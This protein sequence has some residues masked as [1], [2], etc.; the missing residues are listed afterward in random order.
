MINGID[1]AGLAD[2]AGVT[3]ELRAVAYCNDNRAG[4]YDFPFANSDNSNGIRIFSF[5]D[6]SNYS[7]TAGDSLHIFGT[8]AQFNGLLQF[9]PDSIVIAQQGI[10]APAPMSVTVLNEMT[11]N[12]YVMLSNIALVDTAEWTGTGSGFNVRVTDG[13]ADTSIVRIDN[14]VDLYNQPAPT[15]TF[16]IAGWVTQFD[17]TNPRNEGYSL[18]PCSAINITSTQKIENNSTRVAIY[19]NPTY[20]QLNIESEVEIESI[21]IHSVLGQLVFNQMNVSAM[22]TQINTGNLENGIYIIS[23]QTEEHVMTQQ[24]KVMK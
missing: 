3:C 6:V 18:V 12:K 5:N 22:N 7:F 15:G 21:Q 9:T 23:I 13:S 17:P 4:G 8:V 20:G 2:S 10:A 1:T 24:I 19:P 14:D 11:E 16:N